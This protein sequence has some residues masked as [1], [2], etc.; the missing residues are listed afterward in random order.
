MAATTIMR[1]LRFTIMVDTSVVCVLPKV[2]VAQVGHTIRNVTQNLA[3]LSGRGIARCGWDMSFAVA[4]DDNDGTL[5]ILLIP[6]PFTL[7]AKNFVPSGVGPQSSTQGDARLGY[8]WRGSD[9]DRHGGY[10]GG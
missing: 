1:R 6:A 9:M 2:R 8:L 5:D 7:T 10:P 3:V 4:P